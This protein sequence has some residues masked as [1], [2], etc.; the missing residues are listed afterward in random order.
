MLNTNI[1]MNVQS[2]SEEILALFNYFGIH[3]LYLL[4]F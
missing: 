2:Y 3:T 1:F 4:K